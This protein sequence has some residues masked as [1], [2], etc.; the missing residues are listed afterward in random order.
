MHMLL[1][2]QHFTTLSGDNLHVSDKYNN[3]SCL[4]ITIEPFQTHLLP[5][6]FLL[7]HYNISWL[8][9]NDS[10]GNLLSLYSQGQ[11]AKYFYK[12]SFCRS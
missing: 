7:T 2:L 9:G 4:Q 5:F 11:H 12:M 3:C 1:L 8:A 10:I 6:G